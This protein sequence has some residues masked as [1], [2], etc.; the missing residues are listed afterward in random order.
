MRIRRP[1]GAPRPPPVTQQQQ[2]QLTHSRIVIFKCPVNVHDYIGFCCMDTKTLLA[3]CITFC[4]PH[5][6][7]RGPARFSGSS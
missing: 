6:Y 7:K 3:N 4:P 1:V 2:Q 5:K